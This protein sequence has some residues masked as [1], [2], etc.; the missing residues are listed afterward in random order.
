[1]ERDG[2]MG[3]HL[4]GSRG[5]GV[6]RLDVIE[7]PSGRL[8]TTDEGGTSADRGGKHDVQMANHPIE[9]SSDRP[10]GACGPNF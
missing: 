9:M 5:V 8:E 7:G 1:M 3:V 10:L 4:D 2:K 6:S